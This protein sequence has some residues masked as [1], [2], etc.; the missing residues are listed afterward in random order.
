LQAPQVDTLPA[1]GDVAYKYTILPHVFAD[2]TWVQGVQ[3]LPSNPRVVHHCNMLWF[4]PK[5]GIKKSNF[6]TGFVPGNEPMRMTDGLAFRLPKGSALAL[7]IHYVTTGKEEKCRMAVGLRYAREVVQKQLHHL[8]LLNTKFAIPPGAALHPVT[9]AQV[10]PHDSVG[11]GLFC[12]MHLRG[13]AMTF[14]A[15]YPDGRS[16][17]LLV[18]PNYSFDW[19]TPYVWEKGKVRFPAG[20]RIECIAHYDNSPF[21][22]YNPD[23]KATVRDGPQTYHEMM[24]GFFFYTE[25]GEKLDLVIDPK[26]GHVADKGTK[27]AAGGGR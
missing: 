3:I 25:A 1:S 19:Q 17:T 27:A 9:D 20:T 10:L 21:N 7:Q 11:I 13:R 22:P 8:L 6:I 26:T 12:H 23:P 18:I 24:N 15:H 16:E 5:E 4:S 14:K 2:D